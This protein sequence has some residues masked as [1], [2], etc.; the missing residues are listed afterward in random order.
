MQHDEKKVEKLVEEVIDLGKASEI[1]VKTKRRHV[2]STI[3]PDTLFTFMPQF[4]W[5]LSILKNK[6]ISPRYCP[7]DIGYLKIKNMKNLA[8]PMKCFC[9]IN[10]QK[11]DYHM[12]WYGN[13]GIAFEKSWGMERDIQPVHYL[14]ENSTLRKDI[15]EVFRRILREDEKKETKTQQMLKDYLLHELM[16]C[17][18]YQGTFESRIT[19]KKKRKCFCDECEWRFVPDVSKIGMPEVILESEFAKVKLLD[20]YSNSMDGIKDVSLCFEY[21]EIKHIIIQTLE[22]YRQVVEKL[23]EWE[24]DDQKYDV[25]SKIIVWEQSRG[26]F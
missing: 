8:F 23:E 17:K 25:L 5:L 12:K 14:N 10:L 11:L 19:H 20:E 3:H 1:E 6:M 15:T 26:D 21:N 7:E 18:P 22:E 2:P 9:D 24:I 4:K 13:Y 16:F